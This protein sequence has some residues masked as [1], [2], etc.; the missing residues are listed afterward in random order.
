MSRANLGSVTQSE[1]G[2]VVVT[3]M[4]KDIIRRKLIITVGMTTDKPCIIE[5]LAGILLLFGE[6]SAPNVFSMCDP[7]SSGQRVSPHFLDYICSL[8]CSR[9][10]LQVMLHKL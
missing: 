8:N 4:G 7:R 3:N 2:L 9:L 1:L 5:Y 6:I 10:L